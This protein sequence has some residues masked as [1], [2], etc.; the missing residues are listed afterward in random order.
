MQTAIYSNMAFYKALSICHHHLPFNTGLLLEGHPD[1]Q[2]NGQQTLSVL[3]KD[4]DLLWFSGKLLHVFYYNDDRYLTLVE[5]DT[6]YEW[7]DIDPEL[8]LTESELAQKVIDTI[9]DQDLIHQW[10]RVFDPDQGAIHTIIVILD[11]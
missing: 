3:R 4:F 1:Y 10:F 11:I 2:E 9:D 6:L 8:D 7:L 5:T